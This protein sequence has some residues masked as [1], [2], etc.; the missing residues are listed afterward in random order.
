M[1]YLGL[2]DLR[3]GNHEEAGRYFADALALR[4]QNGEPRA[5]A[6]TLNNLGTLRRD[7]GNYSDAIRLHS[8]SVR[9]YKLHGGERGYSTALS[10]LGEA[11]A[12]SEQFDQAEKYQ[13]D[14]LD[15]RLRANDLWGIAWSYLNLGHLARWRMEYGEA[16][17]LYE[18]SQTIQSQIG[19][20]R[21]EA[22]SLSDMG[23]VALK[24]G[25]HYKSNPKESSP[26]LLRSNTY[27]LRS[28]LIR[29]ELNDKR[30][31]IRSFEATAQYALAR[32][33]SD[34]AEWLYSASFVLRRSF[35]FHLQAVENQSDYGR[36]RH[37]E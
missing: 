22:Y 25:M 5:I 7:E 19:D 35:R 9:I 34:V 23:I 24:Q 14:S 13:Q 27:L 20:L 31:L 6:S 36:E 3:L 2:G 15:Q 32:G 26:Y 11:Y 4:R 18:K 10:N 1:N 37:A 33:R 21:G 8:E 29:Q 16:Q 28:L 17:T 12:V 30:G